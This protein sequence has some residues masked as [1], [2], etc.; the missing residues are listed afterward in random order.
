LPNFLAD[1]AKERESLNAEMCEKERA[2][3]ESLWSICLLLA[4]TAVPFGICLLTISAGWE[5]PEKEGCVSLR[6]YV[7]GWLQARAKVKQIHLI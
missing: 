1:F 6:A 5:C 4:L 7:P 3:L 2:P